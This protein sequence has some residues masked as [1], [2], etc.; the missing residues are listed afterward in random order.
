MIGS[1][2]KRTVTT[3]SP[4]AATFNTKPKR[5]YVSLQ[6]NVVIGLLYYFRKSLL[7]HEEDIYFML[8]LNVIIMNG[9]GLLRSAMTIIEF[10]ILMF[11]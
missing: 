8:C 11:L 2:S 10:L 3:W 4:L 6:R 1:E 5:K 9:I 7:K